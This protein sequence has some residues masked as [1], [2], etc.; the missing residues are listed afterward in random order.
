LTNLLTFPFGQD[1]NGYVFFKSRAKEVIIRGGIN[2]YPAEIEVF[3]RTHSEVLDCY[4][5]GLNDKRVGE[6]VCVWIKR[7]SGSSLTRE[8][9]AKYCEGKIAHFKVPKHVKFVEAFPISANGKPQKFKM[10]EQ[11]ARDIGL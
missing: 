8:C 6:E 10:A 4:C 5:F 3:M 11:M 2:I 1:E 9:I 7:V